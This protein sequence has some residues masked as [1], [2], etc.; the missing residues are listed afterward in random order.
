MQ[1][2]SG[3]TALVTAWERRWRLRQTVGWL[4]RGVIP[5][6]LLGILLALL[7]RLRPWLTNEQVLVVSVI[8]VVAGL[9]GLLGVVW[10]RPQS[11]VESARRFDV[12]F[13][14]QERVSTALELL[15]GRI[16]AHPDLVERQVD[17]AYRQARSVQATEQL[18]FILRG[19]EW[20]VALILAAF[21][22]L[23]VILPNN[24]AT[25]GAGDDPERAAII[26][27]GIEAIED[28]IEAVAT[29]PML[30]DATREELLEALE[31]NLTILEDDAI[32][33]DEALAIMGDVEDLL[34][35]EANQMTQQLDRNDAALQQAAE[36]LQRETNPAD[37]ETGETGDPSEGSEAAPGSNSP[38][39]ALQEAIDQLDRDDPGSQSE[40]ETNPAIDPSQIEEAGQALRDTNSTAA[41]FLEDAATALRRN[42]SDAAR[43]ALEDA[44]ESLEQTEQAQ[45]EGR[46]SAEQLEEQADQM[47]QAQEPFSQPG[48]LPGQEQAQQ[49]GDQQGQQGEQQGNQ[50]G[51]VGQQGQGEQGQQG[52]SE[53][54]QQDQQGQQ[55][56]EQGQQA[57]GAQ[58]AQQAGENQSDQGASSPASEAGSPGEQAGNLSQ[59]TSGSEGGE[60]GETDQVT[61]GGERQYQEVF[62]PRRLNQGGDTDIQLEPDM[63]DSPLRE[64]DFAENPLGDVTVPYDQVFSDYAG[65]ANE[66]LESGY[67]PLTLRDVVRDYFTSLE[68]RRA[69][70]TQSDD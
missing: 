12:T 21:L 3:L 6:L 28:S 43:E 42:E 38:S 33:A 18:P 11:A 68:P 44:Q 47:E 8:A 57:S 59:D 39:E 30:D 45:Q 25:A 58:S 41:D 63:G 67:I 9:I 17:D 64:G 61:D 27:Q 56:G 2:Q 50:Q 7:S 65:A 15:D 53:T 13:G 19:Q 60:Q 48:G 32:S 70:P 10:L 29:D 46:D 22:G 35:R 36:A 66:A 5:G 52:Q 37:S 4:A 14:L 51:D 26:D 23:L 20:G 1:E 54:G 24:Q 40:T 34:R 62:D 16:Q 69:A 31:A 49:Q 55:P